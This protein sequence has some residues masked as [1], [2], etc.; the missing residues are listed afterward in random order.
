MIETLRFD[1]QKFLMAFT[2][3]FIIFY[4]IGNYNITALTDGLDS[5]TLFI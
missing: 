1:V 2:L 4:I 5:W 3:P